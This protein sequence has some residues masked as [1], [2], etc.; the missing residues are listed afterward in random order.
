MRN[1]QNGN[2]VNPHIHQ[3]DLILDQFTILQFHN[4][5]LFDFEILLVVFYERVQI[6]TKFTGDNIM[7]KS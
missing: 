6:R 4:Q 5:R 7:I 1:S 3:I 2:I